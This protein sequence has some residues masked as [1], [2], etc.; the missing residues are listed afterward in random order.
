MHCIIRGG[1]AKLRVLQLTSMFGHLPGLGPKQLC[2]L[3]QPGSIH[4]VGTY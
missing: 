2:L 1:E 4:E 3:A